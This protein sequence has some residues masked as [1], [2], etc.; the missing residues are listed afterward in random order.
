MTKARAEAL[1]RAVALLEGQSWDEAWTVLDQPAWGSEEVEPA[2]LEA[3]A[4]AAWWTGQLDE[5]ITAREAAYRAW[6][7][8]GD[9]RGA[10]R[11][12]TWLFEHHCFRAQPAIGSAW[13]RR[14]RRA[15]GEMPDCAE[16][17]H[18]LIREAQLAHGS[19]D[20]ALAL[21]RAEA[22]TALGRRLRLP[23]IE[24]VGLEATG[25][26]LIDQGDVAEGMG[27]LDEAMLFAI[28]GRLDAYTTGRVFC[29]MIG[30]CDEVG[31]LRRAA[32]WTDAVQAW[33]DRHPV[34]LFP[35]LCRLH[36]AEVLQWRGDWS[37]AEAEARR[38]CDELV[39]LNL[40]NAAA[41][42]VQVGEIRRRIGD[43]DGAEAAF[44]RAEELN[45]QAWAGLALL[46]LAQGRD[47]EAATSIARA[48]EGAGTSRLARGKLLRTYVQVMV[49]IGRIDAASAA[50][51]ELDAIA[52]SSEN[53]VIDAS[54]ATARGHLLLIQG[55]CA[56]ACGA[57]NEA[58]RLWTELDAPY[59]VATTRSLMGQ[60][61]RR[62]G[63]QDGA[64]AA[65]SAAEEIFQQL[66]AVSD[67]RLTDQHPSQA[68]RPAGLS[69]R[70]VEVLQLVAAGMTN[71]QMAAQ[72]MLSEKTIARHV[73]NIF[74]KI[75]TSS[76]AAAT[77]FAF[78]HGL[79]VRGGDARS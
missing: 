48:L 61:C 32:E 46:R 51:E 36:Q 34:S 62:N 79:V 72:L 69:A 3:R 5:C 29:S 21:E 47:A 67:A 37:A 45:G 6:D 77:A 2:W 64:E 65:F 14:A 56:A 7:A 50:V 24:A 54:A 28:E 57:L 38:A 58:L 12:A 53:P 76:R 78:E 68:E 18:L 19:G 60:A 1:S 71:R 11:N 35:G 22:A 74:V 55:D 59:E 49:A 10:G 42:F 23:D 27:H 4:E 43:H 26:I 25:R 41:G 16:H 30:A 20:L 73:S 8:A 9:A 31:D 17:G 75:G 33:S 44:R 15:V 40:P 63:D 39:S 70:E 52:S 13:L 66:G